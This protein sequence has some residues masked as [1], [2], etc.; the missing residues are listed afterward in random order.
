MSTLESRVIGVLARAPS[1]RTIPQ[2]QEHLSSYSREDVGFAVMRLVADGAIERVGFDG[3]HEQWRL[4]YVPEADWRG[5]R[6]KF[7]L[8]S[9]TLMVLGAGFIALAILLVASMPRW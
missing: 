4:M 3:S 9:A 6:I 7:G 5:V 8:I 1:G 2:I